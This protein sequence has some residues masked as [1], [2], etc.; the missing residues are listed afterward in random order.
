LENQFRNINYLEEGNGRQKSAYKLLKKLNLFE[1]LNNYNPVLVGT[2]PIDIDISDSDL[3]IICEVYNHDVF[4]KTIIQFYKKCDIFHIERQ[5]IGGLETSFSSFKYDDFCIEVFG[6]PKP[7]FNQNGY[8]H[9][10][11]EKKILDLGGEKLKEEIKKLKR[12]G[13]KTEPAFAKYLGL[14]GDPFEEILKLSLLSEEELFR[15]VR[16]QQKVIS[17]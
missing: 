11:I 2:I 1:I 4:E 6:Q 15:F 16:G 3:D 8:R 5:F 12:S 9:M 13:M 17:V 10:I 14:K 7:V